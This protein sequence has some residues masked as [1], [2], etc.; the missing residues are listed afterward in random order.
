[1]PSECLLYLPLVL[2]FLSKGELAFP[3]LSFLKCGDNNH[4]SPNFDKSIL[5]IQ[6]VNSALFY[7]VIKI[8]FTWGCKV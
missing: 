7:L 2:G 6:A 8:L 4:P 1:M 3:C 5:D